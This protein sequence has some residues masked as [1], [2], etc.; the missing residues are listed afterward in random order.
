MRFFI[1]LVAVLGALLIG[2]AAV[3]AVAAADG[4]YVTALDQQPSGQLDVD[5]NIDDG[6]GVWWTNPIWI[7]I[8][9]V[10]VLLLVAIIAMAARGG[11]TTVIK[12]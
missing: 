9:I 11:G 1:A 4:G 10:A 3:P 2:G 6:E 12:D 5:I 7:G 8:G